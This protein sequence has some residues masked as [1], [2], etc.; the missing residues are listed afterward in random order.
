MSTET[1]QSASTPAAEAGAQPVLGAPPPAADATATPAAPATPPAVEGEKKP[2]AA[3]APADE[4]AKAADEKAIADKAKADEEAKA[5]EAK[6]AEA[7]AA[8]D[9]AWAEFKPKLPAGYELNE[10]EWGEFSAQAKEMGITPEQAQKF[11]EFDAKREAARAQASVTKLDTE[12]QGWLK[13]TSKRLSEAKVD[14]TQATKTANRAL[15]KYAPKG[16]VEFL[17]GTGFDAHPGLFEFIQNVGAAMADD[18]ISGAMPGNGAGAPSQEAQ[19][20]AL[21]PTMF[22]K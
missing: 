9:K 12:R 22:P 5:T 18:S 15:E 7:K 8:A 4:A 11:V 21:Y 3:T 17:K 1:P 14:V 16:F 20:R 10:K 13:D 19:L 2:D 6:K